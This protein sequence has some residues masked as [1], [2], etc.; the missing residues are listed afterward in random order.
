V[1]V[2]SLFCFLRAASQWLKTESAGR[3]GL[4]A[5]A[6]LWWSWWAVPRRTGGGEGGRGGR[7]RG[8]GGAMI[9]VVVVAAVGSWRS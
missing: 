5:S 9:A 3:G 6:A 2:L 4:V 1:A 8:R 7:G